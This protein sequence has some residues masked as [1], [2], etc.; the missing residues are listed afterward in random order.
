[1]LYKLVLLSV[2]FIIKTSF[3]YW[4]KNEN[5]I[6]EISS[7]S[8][9]LSGFFL[10][11]GIRLYAQEA[12]ILFSKIAKETVNTKKCIESVWKRKIFV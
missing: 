9:K 12:Q 8:C 10:Y 6:R 5:L 4:V 2:V 11:F 1:M 3:Y 7:F